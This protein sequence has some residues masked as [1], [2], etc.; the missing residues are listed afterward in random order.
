MAV[1]YPEDIEGCPEAGRAD[2]A[3]FRFLREAA[4][5]HPDYRCWY[6]RLSG[7]FRDLPDF[8][9]YGEELG[10]LVLMVK[11]WSL[12]QIT[13]YNPFEFTVREQGHE[14]KRINPDK[15]VKAC[16]ERLE[17]RLSRARATEDLKLPVGRMTV[18]P[19]VDSWVYRE[20]GIRWFVPAERVLFRDEM[21]AAGPIF[22][23]RRGSAFLERLAGAMPFRSRGIGAREKDLLHR[24]IWPEAWIELPH[25][26]GS[27]KARF[28]EEVRLLDQNQARLALR[29][30]RGHRIIKGPPG[31]GKTLMLVARCC[32]LSRFEPSARRFLL[33][34]YNI[35]LVNY[36]RRLILEKGV[37]PE[38]AGIRVCHFF[39]LCAR[40]LGEAIQYENQDADYYESVVREVRRKM[41]QGRCPIAPFDA[42]FVDEAQDFSNPML[43]IVLGLLAPGGDLVLAMDA[44]QDLY[45]RR[46]PLGSLGI[47]ARGRTH[48]LKQVY[49][50]TVEIFRFTQCFLGTRPEEVGPPALLDAAEHLQGPE[51]VLQ[52]CPDGDAVEGFIVQDIRERV[53]AGEFK[54]AEIAV[55]YDDKIY[56]L[57]RF[58]YGNRALPVRMLRAM[59]RAGIPVTWVSMDVRTK[60]AFDATLDRVSLIS[61]HSSKGLDFDL[62]YLLGADRVQPSAET[63][64]RMVSLLY[65]A[66]TRAK[67]LL[68]IPYVQKT[69]LIRRMEQCLER[70]QT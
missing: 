65:V 21:A 38:R 64:N 35:A 44:Y 60:A 17:E 30:G 50:N 61:I 8:V 4:R 68:V 41:E 26:K 16:A 57:E 37:D 13:G 46:S 18:L 40:I 39:E 24:L 14:E 42:I 28:Q 31:S 11:A 48:R 69:A 47:E 70:R 33:V 5:P 9:L 22:K 49:R 59:D 6:T 12:E 67:Y 52:H 43:S 3:V 66:M 32:Q 53:A 19:N 23:D 27:G 10:L 56:A 1:M 7:R 36:L 15:E 63:G 54:Y 25:R 51:P 29:L 20:H 2:K 62:V 45:A 34:C 55:I 58:G